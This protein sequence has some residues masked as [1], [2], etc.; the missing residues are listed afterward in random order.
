MLENS[1]WMVLAPDLVETCWILALSRNLG[2]PVVT[3][4]HFVGGLIAGYNFGSSLLARGFMNGQEGT[5]PTPHLSD[6]V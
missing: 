6:H 4:R 1:N 5:L 3:K 2:T